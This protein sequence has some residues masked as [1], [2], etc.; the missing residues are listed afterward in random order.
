MATKKK[1]TTPPMKTKAKKPP[2]DEAPPELVKLV[3]EVVIED[4]SS[5]KP[6][7]WNPNEMTEEMMQSLEY[8]LLN[9]GWL[10]SQALLIWRTD[11]KGKVKNIIIDGEHRWT[12]AVELG[13]TKGP[14]VFLDGLTMAKAKALTIKMNQKRGNFVDRLLADVVRDIQLDIGDD[15]SLDLG[16]TEDEL[17]AMMA[18]DP[19]DV[20]TPDGKKP[21]IDEDD[22]E[23]EQGGSGGMR[24]SSSYVTQVQLFFATE[25][26]EEWD[27]YISKL[28]KAYGT[29]NVTDTVM[30]AVKR[31]ASAGNPAT[32]KRK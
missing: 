19:T 15:I 25:K 18:L 4:L 8:G 26:R 1:P 6:N 2:V 21:T 12:K 32:K 14:M 10:V 17:M 5:V 3:G 30:E 24:G 9:D 13:M 31:A 29:D 28:S 7:D 20:D 27:R 23:D 11:E 16:I 22:D